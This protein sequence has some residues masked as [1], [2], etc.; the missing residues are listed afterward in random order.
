MPDAINS[1]SS[2][3]AHARIRREYA[4]LVEEAAARDALP[5]QDYEAD[6][7]RLGKLVLAKAAQDEK[8]VTPVAVPPLF[9]DSTWSIAE[10]LTPIKL[11]KYI[12]AMEAEGYAFTSDL[13]DALADEERGFESELP[14][15]IGGLQMKRPEIRRLRK[16][17]ALAR[18]VLSP[19]NN[20]ECQTQWHFSEERAP[21]PHTGEA[22]DE[23]FDR[24]GWGLACEFHEAGCD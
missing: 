3:F 20:V 13:L 11:D 4:Q 8:K 16:A 18:T 15:L 9:H 12:E 22:V 6:V 23:N 19:A 14:E 21:K 5:L 24:K 7:G 1:S 10:L 2:T 17:L